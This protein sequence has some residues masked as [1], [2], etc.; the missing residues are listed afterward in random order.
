[1]RRRL[2]TPAMVRRLALAVCLAASVGCS[3]AGVEQG[4]AASAETSRRPDPLR[5]VPLAEPGAP[6][7][8]FPAPAR[9]VAE[10]VSPVWNSPQ[11]HDEADEAG[12]LV[13]ALGLRPGMTVADIGAGSGYH[14]LRLAPVLGPT[15][16][17]IAQ[18]VEARYLMNLAKAVRAKGLENVTLAL[19]DP[20]DP[21][22]PRASVDLALLV[23]MYHEVAQ[24]YAF[25]YNL[26]P[27]VKPGGR[28]AVVDLDRETSR[29]GTPR[30][31]LRCEMEAVGYRQVSVAPLSG[32]VGYL[33]VFE[34]PAE[35]ARPE[36]GSIRPC[37][38]AAAR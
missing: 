33:A 19:G 27:A 14:T 32:D 24:P 6:P 16:R 29:H 13:R 21:R 18:D 4:G 35:E 5:P 20:H 37:R 8:F 9:P 28:V 11:R 26:A 12:Q 25:L 30:A 15:G 31:L 1:M 10:I 23:H 38:G 22:L 3:P 17:L 2:D 36:P 7:G 34:P